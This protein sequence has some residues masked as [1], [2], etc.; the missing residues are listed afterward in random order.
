MEI[1]RGPVSIQEGS[2]WEGK[3]GSPR[4]G[5]QQTPL[6]AGNPCMFTRVMFYT[7]YLFYLLIF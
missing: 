4:V 2:E 7:G 6:V 1:E 3:E 5:F